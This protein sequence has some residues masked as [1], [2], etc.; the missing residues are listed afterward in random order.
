[1]T[2]QECNVELYELEKAKIILESYYKSTS[3]SYT[4]TSKPK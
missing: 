3:P 2:E 4:L 1:M